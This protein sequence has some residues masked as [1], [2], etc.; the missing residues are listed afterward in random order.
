MSNFYTNSC[1]PALYLKTTASVLL[2]R[3]CYPKNCI[4][5][6]ICQN[7]NIHKN[8][9]SKSLLFWKVN[10]AKPEFP[11]GWGWGIHPSKKKL[12]WGRCGYFLEQHIENFACYIWKV[13]FDMIGIIMAKTA[14]L[15]N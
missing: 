2:Y 7:Y 10:K 8:K 14:L 12:L 13:I 9:V 6:D 5:G 3:I 11:E 1:N 4:F 15:K